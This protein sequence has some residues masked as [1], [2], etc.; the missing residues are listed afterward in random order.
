MCTHKHT[1]THRHVYPHTHE[2]TQLYTQTYAEE[3]REREAAKSKASLGRLLLDSCLQLL[4]VPEVWIFWTYAKCYHFY[5]KFIMLT[6]ILS[7]THLSLED[8]SQSRWQVQVIGSIHSCLEKLLKT[9][10]QSFMKMSTFFYLSFR[11][12][13]QYR[14]QAVVKL[15]IFLLHPLGCWVTAMQYQAQLRVEH[16]TCPVF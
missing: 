13:C 6:I 8:T 1:H 2:H 15:E 9:V 5:Y 12:E 10:H 11:W 3:K 4:W 14:I 16:S 7:V